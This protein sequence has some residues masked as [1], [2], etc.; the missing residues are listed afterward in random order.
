MS[1]WARIAGVEMT[2]V[3][4]GVFSITRAQLVEVGFEVLL[5]RPELVQQDAA[6]RGIPVTAH[7][8]GDQLFVKDESGPSIHR[9]SD[10]EYLLWRPDPERSPQ[11]CPECAAGKHS[12]CA[13]FAFDEDDN[14]TG[15][16]CAPEHTNGGQ[17]A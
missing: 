14:E 12:S 1:A 11:R 13:G 5:D 3:S 16:P 15:C 7:S 6:R 9:Y 4:E 10:T 17:D 8:D 2:K